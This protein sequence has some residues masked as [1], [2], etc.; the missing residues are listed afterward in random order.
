MRDGTTR[1]LAVRNFM[2]RW[3][4]Y[5]ALFGL[6]VPGIDNAAHFGGFLAGATLGFALRPDWLLRRGALVAT[7]LGVVGGLL[8]AGA[9]L[10]AFVGGFTVP[11]G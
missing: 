9:A 10:A 8:A 3:L 5:V 7:T 6:I 1:G 4:L 2:L 11:A